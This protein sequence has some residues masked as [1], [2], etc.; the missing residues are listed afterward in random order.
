MSLDPVGLG[1]RAIDQREPAAVRFERVLARFDQRLAGAGEKVVAYG[2]LAQ[3]RDRFID[4]LARRR[5]LVDVDRGGDLKRA[6]ALP[7]ARER[8]VGAGRIGLAE[9]FAQGFGQLDPDDALEQLERQASTGS[10]SSRVGQ[11]R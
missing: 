4:R 8:A 6:V 9:L 1:L 11:I 5:E 3:F 7:A 10:L 2:A